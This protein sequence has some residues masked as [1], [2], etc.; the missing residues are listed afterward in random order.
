MVSP[1]TPVP[2]PTTPIMDTP[3]PPILGRT[4]LLVFPRSA[5]A[6]LTLPETR[7]LSMKRTVGQS[8]RTKKVGPRRRIIP[9]HPTATIIHKCNEAN[10]INNKGTINLPYTKVPTT[11]SLSNNTV[12]AHRINRR[13]PQLLDLGVARNKTLAKRRWWRDLAKS[14]RRETQH[15]F[16]RT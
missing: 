5:E 11:A 12:G 2:A 9:P 1:A 15:R 16:T 8:T 7:L 10:L 6:V 14:A 4:P 3:T 13:W